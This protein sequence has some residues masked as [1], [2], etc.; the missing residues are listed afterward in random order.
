[1]YFLEHNLIVEVDEKAYTDRDEKRKEKDLNEYD[2]IG[3][4]SNYIIESTK[5]S[6]NHSLKSK[7]LK[8]VVKKNICIIIKH[9]N[10]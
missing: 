9:A 7:A 4:I 10:L 5:N 6:T 8:Y 2:E 1:M 3:K